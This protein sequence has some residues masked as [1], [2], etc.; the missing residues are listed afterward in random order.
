[1]SFFG[2]GSLLCEKFRIFYGDRTD[3]SITDS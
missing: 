1:M 2:T 3:Q